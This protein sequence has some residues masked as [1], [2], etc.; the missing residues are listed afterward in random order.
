M[1][2]CIA[3]TVSY[4]GRAATARR[5]ISAAT[6]CLDHEQ[7]S[8]SHR[9]RGSQLDDPRTGLRSYD[10]CHPRSPACLPPHPSRGEAS[11]RRTRLLACPAER[12]TLIE[13]VVDVGQIATVTVHHSY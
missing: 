12:V 3:V 13:A 2:E 4:T 9:S 7:V 8:G 6:Q 10:S 5:A 11:R 1:I